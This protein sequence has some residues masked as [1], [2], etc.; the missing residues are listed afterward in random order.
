MNSAV[1]TIEDGD[2]KLMF[3]RESDHTWSLSIWHGDHWLAVPLSEPMT[4]GEVLWTC[5]QTV[6]GTS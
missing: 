1:I 6:T 5:A 2:T 4:S 3:Q